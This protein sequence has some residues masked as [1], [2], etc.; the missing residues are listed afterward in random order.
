MVLVLNPGPH[1]L[2]FPLLF[3]N[4]AHAHN[5]GAELFATWDVTGRWRISPGYSWLHMSITPDASSQDFT[6]GQTAGHSPEHQF[7]VRSW[8]KVRKNWD[9]DTTLMYVSALGNLAIPSYFRLDSRLG[10]RVGEFVEISITGQN[11]LQARHTEFYDSQI[12]Q[13]EVQRSVFGKVTWR[14]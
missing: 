2:V 11:L 9:S 12:A 14:F 5:Y 4:L 10:W 3:E 13:T 7:Q 6:V 1:H 8:L